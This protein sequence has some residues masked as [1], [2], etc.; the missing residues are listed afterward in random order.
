MNTLEIPNEMNSFVESITPYT[1]LK[2]EMKYSTPLFLDPNNSW[3]LNW[4]EISEFWNNNITGGNITIANVDT[5][6][7]FSISVF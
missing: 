1:T 4:M 6:V 7:D 2:N 3:N 5:G